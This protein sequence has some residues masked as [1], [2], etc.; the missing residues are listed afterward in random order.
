MKIN[1]EFKLLKTIENG[2]TTGGMPKQTLPN[3][4]PFP[5]TDFV[6]PGLGQISRLYSFYVPT[7][8][9]KNLHEL[10]KQSLLETHENLEGFGASENQ[11]NQEN[12][13][14]SEQKLIESQ[15][16]MD[17]NELNERNK[18]RMGSAIHDAFLHPKVIKTDKLMLKPFSKQEPKE[19]NLKI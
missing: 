16:L 17:P 15:I 12:S 9:N 19:P 4:T 10:R 13:E 2:F 3:L 18:K 5:A 8:S 7:Y 14:T 6:N 1:M 11:L